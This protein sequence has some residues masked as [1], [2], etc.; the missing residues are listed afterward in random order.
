MPDA[1]LAIDQGT[2]GTTAMVL[3]D[4]GSVLGRAYRELEATY[5]RPGWVEQDPEAIWTSSLESAAEALEAADL[6]P[7][8]LAGIGIAN[9]RETTVVWDRASGRP[10][11]PAI[12][13]QSRQ[14]AGLCAELRAAG[15]DPLVRE[16]TGLLV[17]PYFAA[18]KIRWILDRDPALRARAAAG[19]LAFGTV[20]SWLL[21]RLTG[22]AVHATEPTNAARTML[23]DIHRHRWDDDLLEAMGIPA[24]VLPEVLP[25]CGELGRTTD[26]DGLPTGLPVA[27]VAGDQQAALF[28][29]CCWRPGMVKSTYGTGS[30]AVLYVGRS[31][32]SSSH[33][34][35]STVC[36][37]QRGRPAYALEG[38]IFTTGAAVQWLRDGLG[39][40]ATAAESEELARRVDDTLGVYVV[41]AFT[42]L[43]AP[44]WDADARGAIVGLTRG[45]GREHVVRATLESIAY[46]NRD[47]VEAMGA[48]AATTIAEL[49]VDGGAAANDLLM[50][51][52]ADIL[53]IT[54][55]RP[56][57]VE[58]TAAGAAFLAGLALGVWSDAGELERARRSE[59]R[60]EP[61]MPPAERERR[62]AG[63]RRA[64]RRV[65]TPQG[66]EGIGGPG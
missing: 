63:W 37:D 12:V 49:R 42:G 23:Y 62:Y 2:T 57:L 25:T 9:Q 29:Q 56:A 34:L 33:G 48:D 64:V 8:R 50:Q 3:A 4:D 44:Y 36:C 1:V 13:W 10:V 21:W 19:R 46:Q 31:P 6:A 39:V 41:P 28:G 40:I 14:T 65:L 45:A 5:P 38:A 53:G 47:I 30:F 26:L 20:D 43:G 15:F 24:A 16:R 59:R 22:G 60:F 52:Q 54:V 18:T 61:A 32:C 7:G 11:Y 55:D 66:D 27:G 17:D 51:L 58:S 35:L